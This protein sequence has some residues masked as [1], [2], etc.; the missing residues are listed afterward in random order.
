MGTGDSEVVPFEIE[1]APSSERRQRV[2]ELRRIARRLVRVG[3]AE[4]ARGEELE[5]LGF[6]EFDA[7][8]L[9]CAE[10]GGADVFLSTDDELLRVASR[11][12]R[13]L[14]LRVANPLS[15]IREVTG[16]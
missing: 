9:A 13:Q 8:H 5:A 14:R 3:E 7:L 1:Q 11:V 15:W 10:S 2:G 12:A 4:A 16:Q 6:R